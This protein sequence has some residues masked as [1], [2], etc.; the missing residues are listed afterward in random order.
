MAEIMNQC[1]IG[2]QD[3]LLKIAVKYCINCKHPLCDICMKHHGKFRAMVEHKILSMEEYSKIPC[4][5]RNFDEFCIDHSD[6][7]REYFCENHHKSICFECLKDQ[8][9]ACPSIYKITDTRIKNE[10]KSDV[11][12]LQQQ[13]AVANGLVENLI[14]LYKQNIKDLQSKLKSASQ[15]IKGLISKM[16]SSLGKCLKQIEDRISSDCKKIKLKVMECEN[17]HESINKRRHELNDFIKYGDN[18]HLFLKLVDFKT[19]QCKDEK[20][21]QDI[22]GVLHRTEVSFKIIQPD[23]EK[24]VSVEFRSI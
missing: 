1:E 18:F 6:E 20:M 11:D 23:F 2:F 8:H 22:D 5:V 7:R 17:I 14:D 24:L 12:A 4:S 9:K 13:I 10:L 3:G 19:E 21:L 15:E 16:Q